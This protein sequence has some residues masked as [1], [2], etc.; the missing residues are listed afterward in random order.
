VEAE[1]L[2]RQLSRPERARV[3]DAAVRLA[4]VGASLLPGLK[5]SQRVDHGGFPHPVQ[6]HRLCDEVD[7]GV[8]GQLPDEF[9]QFL[10]ESLAALEPG[11][12]EAELEGGP[13]GVVVTTEI[14]SDHAAE[15]FP[16]VDVGA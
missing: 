14:V 6:H 9:G 15:C 11:R 7:L 2:P 3:R 12:V 5:V 1:G 13:V 10:H 4:L 8:L 16:L